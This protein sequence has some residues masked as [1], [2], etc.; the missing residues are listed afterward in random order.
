MKRLHTNQ[1]YL[2]ILRNSHTRIQTFIPQLVSISISI[3]TK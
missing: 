2:N 1:P 3:I